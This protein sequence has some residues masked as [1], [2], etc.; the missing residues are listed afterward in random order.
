M[1]IIVLKYLLSRRLKILQLS[2]NC[3]V[4]PWFM[5]GFVCYTFVRPF[6]N[7]LVSRNSLLL[8]LIETKLLMR[9]TVIK[10]PFII[11][12]KYRVVIYFDVFCCCW[13]ATLTVFQKTGGSCSQ[14][15]NVFSVLV[16]FQHTKY[17]CSFYTKRLTFIF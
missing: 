11:I 2:E 1:A 4:L 16:T 13:W 6:M 8:I 12:W 15:F 14:N 5:V 7:K 10:N 3:L 9:R 17:S